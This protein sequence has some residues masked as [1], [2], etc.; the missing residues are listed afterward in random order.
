MA[1]PTFTSAD[2]LTSFLYELMRDH[3]PAGEVEALV[4][5]VEEEALSLENPN[6]YS[7]GWLAQYAA[8]LAQRLRNQP[9]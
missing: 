1:S 9:V 2:R 8:D 7:N 4:A 6:V 3:L 5:S